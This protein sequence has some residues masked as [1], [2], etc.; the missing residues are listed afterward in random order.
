MKGSLVEVLKKGSGQGGSGEKVARAAALV[1]SVIKTQSKEVERMVATG[2][3][4]A[5]AMAV[6]MKRRRSRRA[7]WTGWTKILSDE[8]AGFLTRLRAAGV[9]GESGG[10]QRASAAASGGARRGE[11][12]WGSVGAPS[13]G[14][15]PAKELTADDLGA[16]MQSKDV[17]GATI[18]SGSAVSWP[19]NK[20]YRIC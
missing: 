18:D 3:A 12:V 11:A 16:T 14:E 20:R 6:E 1:R 10:S 4:E 13:A 15:Q 19:Q 17:E 2:D 7:S 8:K 5:Q 9:A